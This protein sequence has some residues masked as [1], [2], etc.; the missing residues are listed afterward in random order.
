[1]FEDTTVHSAIVPEPMPP[2]F[3][4]QT[5]PGIRNTAELGASNRFD[6]DT[7]DSSAAAITIGLK[8]EPV[9][10]PAPAARFVCR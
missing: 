7:P 10:R 9:C 4:R 6:G 2:P 8:A 1:V 5:P 3:T